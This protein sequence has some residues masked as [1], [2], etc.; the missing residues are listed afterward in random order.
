MN[1]FIEYF[2]VLFSYTRNYN[3]EEEIYI[4][5]LKNKYKEQTKKLIS[6]INDYINNELNSSQYFPLL[7]IK[8]LLDK[9]EKNLKEKYIEFLFYY[10]KKFDVHKQ[11]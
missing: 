1:N 3:I 10:L 9:S 11:N 6:C 7:K 8:K 4:N 2:N 5:K